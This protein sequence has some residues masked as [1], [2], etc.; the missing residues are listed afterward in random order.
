MWLT[1]SMLLSLEIANASALLFYSLNRNVYVFHR[2]LSSKIP[3]I[4]CKAIFRSSHKKSNVSC[5]QI[6]T[7]ADICISNNRNLAIQR[8]KKKEFNIHIA[9]I[10]TT[11]QAHTKQLKHLY[12]FR[13]FIPHKTRTFA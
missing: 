1:S 6:N 9:H 12:L 8:N 3:K 5:R 11:N 4:T 13:F 10:Y 2:N 7:Y